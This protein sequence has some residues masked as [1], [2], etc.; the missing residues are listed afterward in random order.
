MTHRARFEN[1][2]GSLFTDGLRGVLAAHPDAAWHDAGFVAR[3][4]PRGSGVAVIS[5]GGS[6]HEPMHVGLI[7]AGLLDAACPGLIFTSPN[8]VQVAAA[9][10]SVDTGAG[11]VH[12]VKNYTGD[13]MNFAVARRLVAAPDGDAPAVATEVVLVDDDVATE[14]TSGPGRRGTAA[15]IVVEKICGAAA[16]RGHPLAE[17]AAVGRRTAARARSMAVSVS[18]CN[19]PGA[20]GPSFDLPA[21]QMAFGVG[22]HGERAR[23]ERPVTAA[24]EI[25]TDLLARILPG[26]GL[27]SGDRALVVVNNLGAVTDLETGVLFAETVKQ[28]AERGIEVTRSLVGRF[29]TALDMAGAS[30]TVVPL[31]DELIAL[32]DA[33]TSAPA[34]PHAATAPSNLD[35]LAQALPDDA[36]D[37]GEP[38]VWLSDF[39]GRVQ[40][41]VDE[42]TELDRRAGDGDFG[43]NMAAALGHFPLPLRG[44]DGAVLEALATS[45]LVRAGGTS[46]AVF[47]TFFT[48]LGRALQADGAGFAAGVRAGLDAVVELGGARVGDKTVVDALSPAADVLD[49]GGSLADAAAAAAQG[50]AATADSAAS[51]G[52]ASYLGD[53][54]KGVPDPGAL[55]MSWLFEAA[56]AGR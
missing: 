11:V 56:A 49:G 54:V 8:A 45:Y 9:T 6:G 50:V 1:S 28:L 22:I 39:V 42:L 51:R 19:V 4:T 41:S 48:E 15:T 16:D 25:V 35:P 29:V 55:V 21:G 53:A 24:E 38:N 47:G 36:A 7:G 34:W 31:D 30:I 37:T 5:G 46:G 32:W 10:R 23:D 52:R 13:V 12:V 18:A 43:T 44:T 40:R 33:P 2:A 17:V 3:R 27:G 26:T 14:D 20:D